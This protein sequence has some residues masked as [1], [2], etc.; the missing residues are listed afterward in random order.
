MLKKGDK[1]KI[2]AN[3]YA[4]EIGIL[5][6]EEKK[7]EPGEPQHMKWVVRTSRGTY[8]FDGDVLEKLDD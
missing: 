3:V 1:V 4:G 5:I 7:A 2:K 8:T 6:R